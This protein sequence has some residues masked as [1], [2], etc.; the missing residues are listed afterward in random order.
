MR[1]RDLLQ[2]EGETLVAPWTGGRSFQ[3]SNGRAW[4]I[5][6]PLPDEL[7]W[8]RFNPQ[9]R[10]ARVVGPVPAE[11]GLLGFTIKGYLVGD[12]VVLDRARVAPNPRDL[13][14]YSEPVFLIE[15]GLDRFVRISAGRVHEEGPLIYDSLDMPLGPE[16]DVLD[17]YLD[18]KASV[19]GIP[20]VAPALD[21][22]F[23]ME[24]CRRAEA[25][26]RRAEAE[27]KRREEEAKRHRGLRI[28]TLGLGCRGPRIKT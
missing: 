12:R 6:G 14:R 4:S 7:G 9:G 23:R 16:A 1:W 27:T 11:P 21:V 13:L 28:V 3:G 18:R 17:A 22:A 24:S 20:G 2:V 8:Y 26:R 19:D 5:T 10:K 25:E 15:A